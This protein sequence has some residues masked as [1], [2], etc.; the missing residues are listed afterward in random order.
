MDLKHTLKRAKRGLREEKRLYFIAVSSMAV[1]FLCVA[2]VLLGVTNLANMAERWGQSGRFS[3]Y[4]RDGA[5]P[6]D[7]QQLRTVLEAMPEVE[8]VEELTSEEARVMFLEQ[9]DV[10]AELG[11][12]PA[13]VFPASLEVALVRGTPPSRL[14]TI[15]ERL[16]TL[17]AVED[18]ET[19]RGW[20]GRLDALISAGQSLAFV[21]SL[22]VGLCLLAVIGNTIRLAVA[23]RR[24]EIE[25]MKLCGATDGFV[26]GPFVLEGTFQGF[27]SAALAVIF[28]FA[29]FLS[30]R[31][32]LDDSVAALTGIQAAFLDGWMVLLLIVG[33]AAVGAIGSALSVKRY[34]AV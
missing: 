2:G 17:R 30:I 7:V 21:L 29:G 19:Y 20:F 1:A 9:S 4:L 5:A 16:G 32:H 10:T 28:L 13:E 18:V 8:S 33:G 6:N 22:L 26:R 11:A 31:G 34:L 15:S 14:D 23:R 24:E 3:I 25:V 27:A 12:L